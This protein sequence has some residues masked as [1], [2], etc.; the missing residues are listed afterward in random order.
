MATP[1][2]G[3]PHLRIAHGLEPDEVEIIASLIHC[4]ARLGH[5]DPA[6]LDEARFLA[7]AAFR[8]KAQNED[9]LALLI[10]LDEG[11]PGE[12]PFPKSRGAKVRSRTRAAATSRAPSRM[13]VQAERVP[14]V[15]R[16]KMNEAGYGDAE[17]RL[18]VELWTAFSKAKG[19]RVLKP[20]VTAAALEYAFLMVHGGHAASQASVARRYGVSSGALGQRLAEVRDALDLVPG[21]R[22]YRI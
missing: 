21:D 6:H 4:L 14:E 2:G 22:R 5:G 20:E 17:V 12:G 18:A 13:A 10:W 11:A 19:P 7:S 9:H 8:G 15:I 1:A 16:E 3:A